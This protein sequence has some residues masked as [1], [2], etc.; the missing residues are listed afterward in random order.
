M[1]GRRLS[2]SRP[3]RRPLALSSSPSSSSSSILG[4]QYFCTTRRLASSFREAA[5]QLRFI[6][7]PAMSVVEYSVILPTYNE[8]DNLPL[9]VSMLHR[10]FTALD[11]AYE[12]V[13]VDDNSP[14]GTAEV[15]RRLQQVYGRDHI[16]L[17]SRPGKMG[18]GS[19]YMD[20]LK[21]CKGARRWGPFLIH[22]HRIP[23]APRRLHSFSAPSPPTDPSP[24]A[25]PDS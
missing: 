3:L 24:S 17:H 6:A 18:L 22:S 11:V 7:L 25:I 14:D 23:A 20:G 13:V 1:T 9:M 16:T 10:A 19:A 21:A 15:A 5:A 12:V 4:L 2:P 8:R